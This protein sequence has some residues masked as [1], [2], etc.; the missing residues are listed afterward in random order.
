MRLEIHFKPIEY[1]VPCRIR[2]TTLVLEGLR[3]AL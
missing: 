1:L 2:M 3:W